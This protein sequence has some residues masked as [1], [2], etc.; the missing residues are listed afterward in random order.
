MLN[1]SRWQKV[2][3][4]MKAGVSDVE[5]GAC[6]G[7]LNL[8]LERIYGDDRQERQRQ[9][10]RLSAAVDKYCDMYEDSP[11]VIASA[12]GRLELIGNYQDNLTAGITLSAATQRDVIAVVGRNEGKLRVYDMKLPDPID[13]S[14]DLIPYSGCCSPHEWHNFAF[15]VARQFASIVPECFHGANVVIDGQ[16]PIGSGCSSSAA[17]ENALTYAFDEMCE[18]GLNI[19]D[20]AT[21][22]KKA[23]NEFHKKGCG[24]L[25]QLTSLVGGV[26]FIDYS[27]PKCP[28]ARQL[29][30]W[31]DSWS[32]I[33]VMVD[34]GHQG[35]DHLYNTIRPDLEAMKDRIEGVIF[36][37][38]VYYDEILHLSGLSSDR[39]QAQ[40]KRARFYVDEHYR[41]LEGLACIM[42]GTQ[43]AAHRFGKLMDNSGVGSRDLLG[44]TNKAIDE[45]VL[46]ARENEAYARVHGGGF[47]GGHICM[48]D[49]PDHIVEIMAQKYGAGKV[50]VHKIR[51]VGAAEITYEAK[52]DMI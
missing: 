51:N 49:N 6:S 21:I 32:L 39:E 27:N 38:P 44:N 8:C 1:A 12:P 28:L 5:T 29:P 42:T 31:F 10:S 23:E 37:G 50:L 52:G 20:M 25:D 17:L 15:G 30:G 46:L 3:S 9:I 14:T 7:P 41:V 48:T 36:S 18:A 13:I 26:V 35:Q 33:T 47:Q 45:A 43:K 40:L 19:N 22:S 4:D 24:Y 2:L 34:E 16:V 11:I